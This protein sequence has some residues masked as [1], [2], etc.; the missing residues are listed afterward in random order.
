M[1]KILLTLLTFLSFEAFSQDATTFILVRHAEKETNVGND[2]MMAKD[3][4][5][6]KGGEER[7]VRLQ[8]LLDK[9][10]I[11]VILSTNYK[12]TRTTVE[13]TAKAKNLTVE[14]YES[15]KAP[16]LEE[17][18]AKHKGGVVLI[19][20]HSNTVPGLANLLLGSNKFANYDDADYGNVLIV[21]V[22]SVGK[23][24]VVHVRY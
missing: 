14:T 10:P 12:R 5:L 15:L 8:Q 6:S 22:T 1:F 3:P 11:G 13:P 17:L 19:A 24:T 7:A 2:Q 21:T 23:G 9:Q 20:G 4:P 18:I 16:Q